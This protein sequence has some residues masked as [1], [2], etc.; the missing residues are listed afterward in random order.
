MCVHLFRF[1]FSVYS[2]VLF[3]VLHFIVPVPVS[4]KSVSVLRCLIW[5]YFLVFLCAFILDEN[6][7]KQKAKINGS[8]VFSSFVA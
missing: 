1:G 4:I 6:Q 7:I 3:S 5:F 8:F 2:F